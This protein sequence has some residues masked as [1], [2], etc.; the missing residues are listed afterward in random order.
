MARIESYATATPPVVGGDM[1]IGTD[2]NDNNATKN[3]TVSQLASFIN[4]GSGFVP[5]TG[6]TGNVNLGANTLI[7]GGVQVNNLQLSGD[8]TAPNSKIYLNSTEGVSGQVLT[9][10]GSAAGVVW[11]NP[12]SEVINV[13][14]TLSSANILAMGTS[15]FVLVPAVSGK[16]IIPLSIVIDFNFLGSAYSSA[17]GLNIV[18][19]N[20]LYVINASSIIT[21]G[22]DNS[23]FAG[24]IS[25]VNAFQALILGSPLTITINGGANPTGGNGTMDV[26]VTYTLI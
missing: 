22:F 23:Y 26:Y 18:N 12:L 17:G 10:Q 24:G 8:L 14:R 5:Y 4:S 11:S 25:G 6:A 3:F 2:V 7:S 9:S 20:A 1:L 15:P 21:A 13:K 19:G 16:A